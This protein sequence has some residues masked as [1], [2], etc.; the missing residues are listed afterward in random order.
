M[1]MKETRDNHQIPVHGH[2][3]ARRKIPT[4]GR[5]L[6]IQIN[7]A[8]EE[9]KRRQFAE[10]R[11]KYKGYPLLQSRTDAPRLT[12]FEPDRE[13]LDF[14]AQTFPD[15]FPATRPFGPDVFNLQVCKDFA[16]IVAH[17]E[18][19]KDPTFKDL[20]LTS[21]KFADGNLE[22]ATKYW[23]EK[24][25][26]TKYP[27]MRSHWAA[28]IANTQKPE[29]GA[30]D[31]CK[32]AYR[33]RKDQTTKTVRSNRKQAQE[34]QLENIQKAKACIP[35]L[36]S[37]QNLILVREKL[38]TARLILSTGQEEDYPH[39][40][41]SF[42]K[43]TESTIR[44]AEKR[45]LE[46]NPVQHAPPPPQPRH[47]EEQV[48]PE[49]QPVRPPK[50]PE[51]D[52]FM[53]MSSIITTLDGLDFDLNRVAVNNLPA[54]NEWIRHK[55]LKSNPV[56]Q[57]VVF[58]RSISLLKSANRS[59]P[60]PLDN[61]VPVKRISYSNHETYIEKVDAKA[62]ERE[63]HEAHGGNYIYDYQLRE[64]MGLQKLFQ[65]FDNFR[66]DP[67]ILGN[68]E[69]FM[70]LGHDQVMGTSDN[71][72]Y[73]NFRNARNLSE[74]LFRPDLSY[75]GYASEYMM[76]SIGRQAKSE[77]ESLHLGGAFD[78]W[79]RVKTEEKLRK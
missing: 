39:L 13:D 38:K 74:N 56:S 55:I 61:F 52:V 42:L 6:T 67:N 44:E 18:E 25:R 68:L 23:V 2:L 21:K 40:K 22:L 63:R 4:P 43:G 26:R 46:F 36:E 53:M 41:E 19:K 75:E 60:P 45:H 72:D 65:D 15:D 34:D 66:L 31:P 73:V 71:F 78:S 28:H 7:P 69:M 79:K 5:V 20:Q 51:N 62:L 32:I 29:F 70:M 49:P 1:M 57:P 30:L 64:D 11:E 33:E 47:Y 14:L 17:L 9:F 76:D 48:V 10:L 16:K 8:V 35:L 37:I 58:E 77:I 12:D 24:T 27:L 59:Q 54:I 3:L 50:I